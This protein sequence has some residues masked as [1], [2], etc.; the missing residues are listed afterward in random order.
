MRATAKPSASDASPSLRV[1]KSRK[2]RVAS[3]SKPKAEPASAG[4]L[5]PLLIGVG[6]GSAVVLLANAVHA[7]QGVRGPRRASSTLWGAL[8][9]TAAVAVARVVAKRVGRDLAERALP[10]L[11]NRAIVAWSARAART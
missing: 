9:K 5:K 3:P 2:R 1:V 6:V 4:S 8:A 11:A 10:E 7:Q